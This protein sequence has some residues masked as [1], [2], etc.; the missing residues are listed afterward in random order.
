MF[1]IKGIITIIST[2]HDYL[3]RE[4]SCIANSEVCLTC[5]KRNVYYGDQTIVIMTIQ[6]VITTMISLFILSC[7]VCSSQGVQP[8]PGE[9]VTTDTVSLGSVC[10]VESIDFRNFSSS[11]AV[12]LNANDTRDCP[13]EVQTSPDDYLEVII[14]HAN[15]TG[16]DY[17][18]IDLLE[19][20]AS[21]ERY[22]SFS[23]QISHCALE[24]KTSHIALH[25]R[26]QSLVKLQT[27]SK[28]KKVVKILT[29]ATDEPPTCGEMRHYESVIRCDG[30]YKYDAFFR[31]GATEATCQI[32]CPSDC[33]CV[34]LQ[35]EV[36]YQCPNNGISG[37][38]LLILPPE[39]HVHDL[40][41][42]VIPN[43]DLT[44]IGINAFQ[45]VWWIIQLKLTHAP[46][47]TSLQQ[48]IFHGMHYMVELDLQ[49]NGIET[50][51]PG[52]FQD[53][54]RLQLLSLKG[55]RLVNIH[56]STF[57]GLN[58]VIVLRL[59]ENEIETLSPDVFRDQELLMLL[60]LSF[61][62][63]S[64][65]PKLN[66]LSRLTWLY[67]RYNSIRTLSM[68][69]FQDLEKLS[70]L[71][72]HNNSLTTLD[73]SMFQGASRLKLLTIDFNRLR[74]I[75]PLL[76]FELPN[77]MRLNISHNSLQD[78]GSHTFDSL[79]YLVSLD[80]QYNK[81]RKVDAK[82]FD[83]LS[84]STLLYV[85]DVPTCCYTGATECV[86]RNPQPPFM[87]CNRLM[88]NHLLRV[89]MWLLGFG[90]IGGNAFV[91]FWRW[92]KRKYSK[93][94]PVQRSIIINL[95]VADLLMG[96][97]MIM[98]ISADAHYGVYFPLSSEDWR[99]GGVCKLAGILAITSSEASVF[100]VTLISVDRFL[101]VLF[102]FKQYRIGQKIV[103]VIVTVMWI[104]AL[105]LAT[106]PTLLSGR[107]KKF[108]DVSQICIGLP[109]V[110]QSLYD[111]ENVTYKLDWKDSM[112]ST[113]SVSVTSG[114]SAWMYYSIAIFLGLNLLCCIIIFICYL[115]IFL[116][117]RK[118]SVPAGRFKERQAEEIR[119]A[120]KM[121]VIVLTDFFCWMP[122]IIIG[123]LVQA[124]AVRLSPNVYAWIAVF[125][126]PINSAVNPF[127]YTLVT[128]IVDRYDPKRRQSYG[129]VP[130]RSSTATKRT[131]WSSTTSRDVT[132]L[133]AGT[134]STGLSTNGSY[135]VN[136]YNGI[137]EDQV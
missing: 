137:K 16:L 3:R 99:T 71:H 52:V 22:L 110:R 133:S 14:I 28:S 37:T 116:A 56:E 44:E 33:S 69:A 67:L 101:G 93:I 127:L 19:M 51:E 109:L 122:I 114:D 79:L 32:T 83:G 6:Q 10:E 17:L 42:L 78:L 107:N 86:P 46:Q 100:F 34:L 13:I 126:L 112:E 41:Y 66:H 36:S 113:F 74:R 1:Y 20:N 130:Y 118:T 11:I 53:L 43:S 90:A 39:S 4:N 120:F 72:L 40:E 117:V 80:L 82:S 70:E 92:N 103:A 58:R 88:P 108:Y 135:N 73:A 132:A 75:D 54:M 5:R 9:T 57:L 8:L 81:L 31:Y 94:Q 85:D 76:W 7:M 25:I 131:I 26:T 38:R 55:N 12:T 24:I 63:L 30:Q 2:S 123:I 60:D 59:S 106:V 111:T 68:D 21:H 47:L 15:V 29:A 49:Y 125:I 77:L 121:S 50:I 129:S 18:Y 89:L 134:N 48:G 61:N 87:T 102:P 119:M 136:G 128:A 124:G 105:T 98:V 104:V 45:T 115:A 27:R 91:I 64:S 35:G 95:A 96:I 23:S 65:L 84:N 97:Y 62:H